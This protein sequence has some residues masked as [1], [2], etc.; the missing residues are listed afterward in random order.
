MD[1]PK[2]P[3]SAKASAGKEKLDTVSETK[4][5]LDGGLSLKEIAKRRGL[6]VET[7]IDHI[8]Q[9]KIAE[10]NYN[11]YNLRNSISKNKFREIYGAFKKVGLTDGNYRLA[12]IKELLGKKCS[13]EDLRLVRL[14]L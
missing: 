2:A 13:Y 10:P 6:K 8:E 1:R 12:P 7:I 9:I 11:I 14:F 3:S 5:M 4:K